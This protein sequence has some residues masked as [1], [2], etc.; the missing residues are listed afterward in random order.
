MSDSI[1]AS[2]EQLIRHQT[3]YLLRR[4]LAQT[5]WFADHCRMFLPPESATGLPPVGSTSLGRALMARLREE[6]E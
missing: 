1:D 6:E 5:R 2:R 3:V 4:E